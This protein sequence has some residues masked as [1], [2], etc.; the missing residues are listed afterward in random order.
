MRIPK[1]LLLLGAAG[2]LA[3]RRALR[4]PYDLTGKAVLITGGSRGLGLALAQEFLARGARVTLMA[5]TEADLKR[6]QAGLKA[7]ER[8]SIVTGN[9]AVPADAARAVQATV[10]AHGRL[11]V[12][13]NNAGIIQLGPVAN[14][15][16]EDFRTAME[17]NAFGPLRL[18]RA[19][20]PHLRGGGRV[21]IVSSLGGKVA[22]PHLTPYV[23]SKFASAGLGQ[24]LRAELAPEGVAVTTVL[25]GLMRTGSP[26]NAPVKGQPRK[27]YAL[28]ATLAASP[29]VSLDAHEAARRVVNALVRGDVEAMI[30]GPAL[31]LRTAQALAPQLTADLLRLGHRALPGPGPSDAMVEGR[32]V[33]S[34]LTRANPIKRSAEEEFN[35]RGAHGH[36]PGGDLN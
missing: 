18:I 32:A 14:A 21:L 11:D 33:E 7:G 31:I 15:T 9:V 30:G 5:R 10:Q 4:A 20:L 23:M 26:L 1:R 24:A 12:L 28:F 8:V 22:I 17:V 29:L 19:A 16:E 3:A 6:A 13:V 34:A 36:A 2:A 25:P 27:E 35:Q